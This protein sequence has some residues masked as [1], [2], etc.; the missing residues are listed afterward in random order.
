MNDELPVSLSLSCFALCFILYRLLKSFTPTS[1]RKFRLI[2]VNTFI[3]LAFRLFFLIHR[4][5]QDMLQFKARRCAE[6]RG[7]T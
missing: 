5:H 4:A 7:G 3:C 1:R 6:E 2:G